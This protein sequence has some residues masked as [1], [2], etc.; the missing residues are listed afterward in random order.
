MFRLNR[1]F[2]KVF[3]SLWL[4]SFMV[5]MIT[6]LVIGELADEDNFKSKVD[7]QV[8][9]QLERFIDRY[10]NDTE[11]RKKFN[12]RKKSFKGHRNEHW[13][14]MRKGLP[15]I[16]VHDEQGKKIL[17][18]EKK[19]RGEKI[20]LQLVS[21]SGKHYDIEYY[22]KPERNSLKSWQGFIFS[23]QALLILLSAT[24]ASFI[25][26][27]IVV[28]PMNKL[29]A[30][31]QRL[32]D[33]EFS[34]RVE[35]KLTRRGDEIGDFAREFNQMAEY[36]EGTLKSQQRLFQNVS[37]ELRAPLARLLAASGIVE[38]QVGRDSKALK[39]I[40]LECE[41]L[42]LLINELLSLAK[43]Q[44]SQHAN[45]VEDVC[46]MIENI[47]AE[48]L[49]SDVDRQINI[50][51]QQQTQCIALCSNALLERAVSNVLGNSL[52]HTPKETVVTINVS[53]PDKNRLLISIEDNGPGVPAAILANLCDPFFRLDTNVD[54]HGLGLGIAKQAMQAQQ[55]SLEVEAVQ[56]NGLRVNL[57]L[58]LASKEQKSAML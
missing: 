27:A 22:L 24:I 56:P 53:N 4:S 39:Q 55:G 46:P 43:L 14:M 11:F 9:V 2:W 36:V 38:Q 15:L 33:G 40:Q 10:E 48:S 28:I 1:L 58:Q 19:P 8:R 47:V 3:L 20:E 16:I 12:N 44:Q 52:K 26:S 29:R 37:H 54:G 25:V 23:V 17:G 41:R 50:F 6:V 31:V 32:K 49:F 42:D 18:G 21:E 57:Y 45:S 5:M 34:V 51:I 7:Y 30:H 35:D 13:S